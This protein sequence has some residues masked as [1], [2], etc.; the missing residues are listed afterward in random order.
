MPS[1]HLSQT[2]SDIGR[3]H[4]TIQHGELVFATLLEEARGAGPAEGTR[5]N[6]FSNLPP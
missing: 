5:R 2:Q 4:R 6:L 3:L 1:K